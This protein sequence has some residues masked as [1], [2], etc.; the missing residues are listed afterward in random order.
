MEGEAVEQHRASSE[1]AAAE[2]GP[3]ADVALAVAQAGGVVGVAVAVG[4]QGLLSGMKLVAAPRLRKCSPSC[5]D[6][7]HGCRQMP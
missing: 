6:P 3:T 1:P 2:A 5:T 7:G 4:P